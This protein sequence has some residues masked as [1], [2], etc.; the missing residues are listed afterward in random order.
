MSN[1][2]PYSKLA[3]G[4]IRINKNAR[5]A[6]DSFQW[7]EFKRYLE[8]PKIDLNYIDEHGRTIADIVL[9]SSST[10]FKVAEDLNQKS[11]NLKKYYLEDIH[12]ITEIIEILK[13]KKAPLAY[14][15]I[16]L[17]IR[18][19]PQLAQVAFELGVDEKHWFLALENK[20]NE[21]W[22]EWLYQN[23]PHHFIFPNSDFEEKAWNLIIR[24]RKKEISDPL[25]FP[26]I[27][28]SWD[29]SPEK[30]ELWFERMLENPGLKS[31]KI[32][33]YFC[34]IGD[35]QS[36]KRCIQKGVPILD[37]NQKISIFSNWVMKY[38]ND[39]KFND[40]NYLLNES[41]KAI[42]KNQ[43]QHTDIAH[44]WA[45]ESLKSLFH[46]LGNTLN[47]D[48]VS[49]QVEEQYE[50]KQNFAGKLIHK[51]M[52]EIPTTDPFGYPFEHGLAI[53][54][55]SLSISKP[56]PKFIENGLSI[57]E[58][59]P[60]FI[61]HL[62]DNSNSEYC[63]AAIL[64]ED[65]R[66]SKNKKIDP[67]VFNWALKHQANLNQFLNQCPWKHGR[68]SLNSLK[69][70]DYTTLLIQVVHDDQYV[71]D[72]FFEQLIEAGA[73]FKIRDSNGKSVLDV[74]L[75]QE[76][77]NAEK[78]LKILLKADTEEYFHRI[79]LAHH[80]IKHKQY[81]YLDVLIEEDILNIQSY[82]NISDFIQETEKYINNDIALFS[83]IEK[84][85]LSK[86]IKN[87]DKNEIKSVKRI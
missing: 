82:D 3:K 33:E 36:I 48:D 34:S 45:K 25:S 40:L 18:E 63:W 44:F 31:N 53:F 35:I 87:S 83:Y 1:P 38:K 60:H 21:N 12:L 41:L 30:A 42:Q 47:Q 16:L 85:I 6:L 73:D 2:K 50:K 20:L 69:N 56:N 62:N 59:I 15:R 71:N 29:L 75:E 11:E 9:I 24:A 54:L 81:S 57:F 43:L 46:I 28:F 8:N 51:I 49:P 55:R 39:L 76:K 68:F 58:K 80:I 32:I 14:P 70:S 52:K 64:R 79:K 13:E 65:V 7:A 23:K 67:V 78:A 77:E 66:Y 22:G 61:D 27:Y 86:N 5:K 37:H 72:V 74:L 19:N 84:H 4:S 10:I 17:E 26:S